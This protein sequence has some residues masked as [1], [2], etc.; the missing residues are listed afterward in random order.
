MIE[1]F[2]FRRYA[3]FS[4]A[5]TMRWKNKKLVRK[6]FPLLLLAAKIVIF[7]HNPGNRCDRKVWFAALCI[8]IRCAYDQMEE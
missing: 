3:S 2:G 5:L 4:D 8:V 7:V 6:N 1:H